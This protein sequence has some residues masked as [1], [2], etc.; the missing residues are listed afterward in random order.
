MC[1][2]HILLA[3]VLASTTAFAEQ[4]LVQQETEQEVQEQASVDFIKDS[5]EYCVSYAD[6]EENKDNAILTCVN[7][8]LAASGY[9]TFSSVTAIKSAIK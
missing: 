5:F 4:D 2:K 3:L 8:E 7:E 9:K 1:M 6:G